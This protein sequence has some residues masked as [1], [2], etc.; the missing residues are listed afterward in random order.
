MAADEL[1]RTAQRDP[2]YMY[3]GSGFSL[4][5]NW[6]ANAILKETSGNVKATIA[7][8]AVPFKVDDY[9]TDYFS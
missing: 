5:Q 6:V 4:L 8:A 2:Y 7:L 9:D 3:V 1:T